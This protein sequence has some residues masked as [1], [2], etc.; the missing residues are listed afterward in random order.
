MYNVQ[1][2][3]NIGLHTIYA[4]TL[5]HLVMTLGTHTST[6]AK[7]SSYVVSSLALHSSSKQ[8]HTGPFGTG[9]VDF[10]ETAVL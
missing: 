8:D 1:L 9:V 4:P 7:E 3:S 5:S 6:P 10:Q 2:H